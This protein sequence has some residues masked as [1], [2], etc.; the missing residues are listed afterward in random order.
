M[1]G[2]RGI[3]PVGDR[4]VQSVADASLSLFSIILAPHTA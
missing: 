1:P 3:M 2:I 4:S